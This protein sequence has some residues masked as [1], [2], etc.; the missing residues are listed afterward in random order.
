MAG[1]QIQ[2]LVVTFVHVVC[3]CHD[4]AAEVSAWTAYAEDGGL[5]LWY[6][7]IANFFFL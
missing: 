7:I 3:R 4:K 5:L 6:D 2:M 1:P